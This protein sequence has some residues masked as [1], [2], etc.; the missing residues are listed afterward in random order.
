MNAKLAFF[1]IPVLAACSNTGSSLVSM[2][3]SATNYQNWSC[4]KLADEQVRLSIA[5]KA[6]SPETQS[7]NNFARS[8]V[9]RADRQRQYDAVTKVI[10]SKKCGIPKQIVAW[11]S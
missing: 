7:A 1:L 6:V 3:V 2:Q 10:H 5:I 4:H 11:M 9:V 8:K